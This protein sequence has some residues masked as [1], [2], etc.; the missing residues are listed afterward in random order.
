MERSN[1]LWLWIAVSSP[2]DHL[3]RRFEGNYKFTTVQFL[4]MGDS[5]F[6]WHHKRNHYILQYTASPAKTAIRLQPSHRPK[7][8]QMRIRRHN[9]ACDSKRIRIQRQMLQ[10]TVPHR[11][12][13]GF[14]RPWKQNQ[15]GGNAVNYPQKTQSR[16]H[17]CPFA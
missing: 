4:G 10:F 8:R 6:P 5:S 13:S 15:A 11:L 2:S 12:R 3:V 14:I 17:N 1:S 7:A 16:F 9:R